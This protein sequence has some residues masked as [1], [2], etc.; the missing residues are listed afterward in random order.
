M[1]L[2]V[3]GPFTGTS[4]RT[5]LTVAVLVSMLIASFCAEAAFRCG[6]HLVEKGHWKVEVRERCGDPDY[7]ATYPTATLP[8]IGVTGELEHWYYNPGPQGFIRRLEFRD[9]KLRRDESM[10]YGFRGE[11]AGPCTPAVINEGMSEFELI[12]HCGEPLSRRVEWRSL[13]PG[14]G[15]VGHRVVP[16]QEWLYGFGENRFRRVITLKNGTVTDMESVDKPG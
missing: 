1:Q 13:S 15:H 7:I 5:W 4:S 6:R 10:G 14:H 16:V 2:S 9:G 3:H 12:A 8:G 11:S